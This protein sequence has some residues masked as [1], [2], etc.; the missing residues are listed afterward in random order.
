M[1]DIRLFVCCHRRTPVPEYP[2]LVPI[3]V[4]AAMA[5]EHFDGFLADDTGENISEKNPGYCELTA[6]Y[7][8]WKNV[9]ADYYG[10]FH[11]RRYLYPDTNFKRPYRIERELDRSL[12]DRLGFGSI[13]ELISEYDL[14]APVGEN[15][16]MSVRNHYASAPCHHLRDLECVERVV[17]ERHPEMVGAV[18]EYLSGAVC[19]F[20]NIYIMRRDVFQNYCNW[21]FPIL[22]EFDERTDISHYSA[23]EQ[24]VDGYLAERLFGIYLTYY[25]KEQKT[26]ELPRVHFHSGKEYILKKI[27]N[28]ILPPGSRRRAAIK[29]FRI[30]Q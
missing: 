10:F 27:L 19:Y 13:A 20:G 15:M 1:A 24:R 8:A 26:L 11:Y 5:G 12:L 17:Q 2:L 3:Q 23:Q 9:W 4:G 7:W 21:L 28:D 25:R 30:G 22:A 14:I 29:Q 6:Q 16:Y 18:Q